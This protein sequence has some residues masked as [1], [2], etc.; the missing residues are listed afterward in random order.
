MAKPSLFYINFYTNNG[1]SNLSLNWNRKFELRFKPPKQIRTF[2]LSLNFKF[3]FEQWRTSIESFN[4]IASSI[5]QIRFELLI[6][7]ERKVRFF[8]D[9]SSNRFVCL[10]SEVPTR[11]NRVLDVG[12]CFGFFGSIELKTLWSL[13]VYIKLKLFGS[14]ESILK[15]QRLRFK[16]FPSKFLQICF[17]CMIWS[18]RVLEIDSI[19]IE[20][21]GSDNLKRR[22]QEILRWMHLLH[23]DF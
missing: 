23:L 6:G 14:T 19:L 22:R 10:I 15:I 7:L 4:Y 1:S 11:K 2:N 8:Y 17:P 20:W 9:K 3:Q 12:L 18:N 13:R 21:S 5:F 16:I